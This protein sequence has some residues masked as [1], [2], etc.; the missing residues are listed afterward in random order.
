M[1]QHEIGVTTLARV[2]RSTALGAVLKLED[3]EEAWL[4]GQASSATADMTV[5]VVGYDDLL[6]QMVGDQV[7]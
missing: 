6:S 7:R 3:G 1:R 4:P 2:S 5:S